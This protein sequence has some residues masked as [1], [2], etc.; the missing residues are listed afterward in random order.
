M[1]K[2]LIRYFSRNTYYSEVLKASFQLLVVPAENDSQTVKSLDINNSLNAELYLTK[3][4]F[5]FDVYSMSLV[6]SFNQ[7]NIRLSN[8]VVSIEQEQRT[9]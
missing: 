5:G 6:K 8:I 7:F 1:R 9:L 2:Y 3:N 4:V